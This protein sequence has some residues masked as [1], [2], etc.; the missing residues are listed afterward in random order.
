M[1]SDNL[2]TLNSFVRH[3]HFKIEDLKVVAD[4]LRPLDFMCKIDLRAAYFS[5]P[6]HQ[7]HQKLLLFHF[8]N[9]TYQF[10]CRP[11]CLTSAPWVFTKMLKPL[12]VYVRRLGL[13]IC[14]YLDDM[15][16]LNSQREGA[17]RDAMLMLHLLENLRF[18]V[19][20]QNS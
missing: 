4:S 11:F 3:H 7:V 12:I 1:H 6:I 8:R 13:R 9:V 20:M 16:I 15:L 2:S 10:K 18:V 14:I 5:V 19:N 17:M